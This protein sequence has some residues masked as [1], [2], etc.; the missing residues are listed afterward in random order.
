MTTTT[1]RLQQGRLRWQRQQQTNEQQSLPSQPASKGNYQPVTGFT[2]ERPQPLKQHF[3]TPGHTES[4]WQAWTQ[5]PTRVS[6]LGHEPVLPE[7][8]REKMK[9]V[10]SIVFH[11]HLNVSVDEDQFQENL[12]RKSQFVSI[13]TRKMW[14]RTDALVNARLFLKRNT[15]RNPAECTEKDNIVYQ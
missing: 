13:L 8:P 15:R 7:V 1:A 9:F 5:V 11:V 14:R 2:Q 12:V 4:S 3:C 6:A 10:F